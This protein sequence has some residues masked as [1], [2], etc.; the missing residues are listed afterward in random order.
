MK[1]ES[2][3]LRLQARA[4]DVKINAPNGAK[5][6]NGDPWENRTPVFAVRGRRLSR[7]TKGPWWGSDP[8]HRKIAP[9]YRI[10]RSLPLDKYPALRFALLPAGFK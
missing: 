10:A 5:K 4:N 1:S 6:A 8:S 2:H 3:K 9:L 7:L